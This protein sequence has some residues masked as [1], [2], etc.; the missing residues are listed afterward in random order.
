[1]LANTWQLKGLV[2]RATD[3]DPGTVD[4]FLFDDRTW[5]VRYLTVETGAWLG[6]RRVLISPLFVTHA[7]WHA[8]RLDVPLTKKQ[9][10]NSLDINTRQTVSRQNEAEYLGSLGYLYYRGGPYLW[11]Q[12]RYPADLSDPTATS[13]ES[14]AE[15]AGK[16]SMDSHLRS[17]ESVTGYHV[18]AVDGEIG[19]VEGFVM[20]DASWAIRYVEVATR[21]WWPG[22]RVLVSPAWIELVSWT[23]SK[24]YVGLTREAI[25][26]GPEYT[27]PAPITQ[28]YDNRLY[29]H[30]D[31]PPYWRDE[32]EQ[33]SS[34]SSR[35]LLAPRTSTATPIENKMRKGA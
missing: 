10:A 9:V 17:A 7:D 13:S 21:N 26:N 25:K 1:M 11:G 31:R 28:E 32:V 35:P 5:A 33:N 12:R 16:E 34:P 27:E 22:K 29:L 6:T 3:G 24:V 18:E 14:V 4:R 19:H 20:D 30:Y 8:K 2:V 23:D 15:R